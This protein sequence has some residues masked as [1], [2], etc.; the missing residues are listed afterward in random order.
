MHIP[1]FSGFQNQRHAGTLFGFDQMLVQ[2]G[3]GK[4]R[5]HC[6]MVFIHAPV[7]K[8]QDVRPFSVAAVHLH[9]QPFDGAL[10]LGIFIVGDRHHG[11]LEAF[12]LHALDFQQVGVGEDRVVYL[13][14]IAVLRLFLQHIP[15]RADVD[16]GGGHNMLP[17]GVDGRVGHL[18]EQL[19]KGMEQRMVGFA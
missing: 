1:G 6:H 2:G 3:Y 14:N 15:L 17:D 7:R 11:N 5:G 10:Q 9:I 4:Q 19:L 18:G 8:D 16:S 12:H 13:Q